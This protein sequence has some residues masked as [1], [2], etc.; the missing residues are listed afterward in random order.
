MSGA[1][2]GDISMYLEPAEGFRS[3]FSGTRFTAA[4]TVTY[5]QLRDQ[6]EQRAERCSSVGF[7]QHGAR[8]ELAPQ[9]S[10]VLERQRVLRG[11][12]C[13]TPRDHL[14]PTYRNFFQGDKRWQF[15][16]LRLAGPAR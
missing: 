15:T 16:G 6:P 9:L 5:G 10:S 1:S 13:A 4:G 2:A 8:S 11:G 14:R 12:S 7:V 3:P